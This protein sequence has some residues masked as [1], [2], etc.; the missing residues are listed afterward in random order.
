MSN[1]NATPDPIPADVLQRWTNEQQ[2]ADLLEDVEMTADTTACL[3]QLT[4][5]DVELMAAKAGVSTE[6][7]YRRLTR[8]DTPP[9]GVTPP[10]V[11]CPA[12]CEVDE[13][14]WTYS[15]G[16]FERSHTRTVA[17]VELVDP[18][19]G[20]PRHETYVRIWQSSVFEIDEGGLTVHPPQIRLDGD[21]MDPMDAESAV[22]LMKGLHHAAE[23]LDAINLQGKAVID[24]RTG[25]NCA[26]DPCGPC[27][28]SEPIWTTLPEWHPGHS[29]R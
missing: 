15:F 27:R 23:L 19:P 21:P 11:D 4:E 2:V 9:Q 22:A 6:E 26:A 25:C 12:W 3:Y 13:C 14:E 28:A 10:A 20:D 24:A 29:S 7:M 17:T 5:Q 1:A 8:I 16:Q 18:I